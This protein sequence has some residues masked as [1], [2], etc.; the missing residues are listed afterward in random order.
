MI[1]GSVGSR[2]IS[3]LPKG[4]EVASFRNYEQ[5]V[6]AVTR[7]GQEGIELGAISIVGQNLY[8][9]ENI[10]GRITPGRVATQGALQGLTWGLMMGFILTFLGSFSIVWLLSIVLIGVCVGVLLAAGSW[11]I[12]RNKPQFATHTQILAARYAVLVRAQADRAFQILQGMT[13][14]L[15]PGGQPGGGPLRSPRATE[16]NNYNPGFGTRQEGDAFG[17][18]GGGGEAGSGS[19]DTGFGSAGVGGIGGGSVGSS[20][21]FD[22]GFAAANDSLQAGELGSR[23]S[24]TISEIGSGSGSEAASSDTASRGVASNEV[25]SGAGETSGAAASTGGGAAAGTAETGTVPAA[26]TEFGSRPD[27]TPKFGVRLTP[28]EREAR[29]RQRQRAEQQAA[30]AGQ[31]GG[32]GSAENQ[33]SGADKFKP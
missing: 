11:A 12:S 24:G 2:G 19:A 29:L 17:C 32:A 23:A 3:Q 30:G 16:Y 13:G 1:S 25:A 15:G 31:A 9:V 4:V 33:T 6:A 22:G 8:R 27:E 5:A 26:P 14:N 21:G 7:L 28:E 20:V 10:V 18:F